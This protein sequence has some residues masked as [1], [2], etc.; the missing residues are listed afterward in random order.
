MRGAAASERIRGHGRLGKR[1]DRRHDNVV[2]IDSGRAEKVDR[3]GG[4]VKERIVVQYRRIVGTTRT[5]QIVFGP[6]GR[7]QGK[8]H[9]PT[10]VACWLQHRRSAESVQQ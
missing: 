2:I 10:P 8:V 5:G 3:R 1:F 4:A 9:G 6:H 7:R